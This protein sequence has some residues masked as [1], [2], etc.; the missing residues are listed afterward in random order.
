ML[1]SVFNSFNKMYEYYN[2]IHICESNFVYEK[3]IELLHSCVQI[4]LLDQGHSFLFI[5]KKTL[6]YI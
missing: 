4:E 3:T 6:I 2:Y 1:N 5:I